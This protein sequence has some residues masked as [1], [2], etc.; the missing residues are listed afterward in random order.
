[1]QED[2]RRRR[3]PAWRADWAGPAPRRGGRDRD[4]RRGAALPARAWCS[5]EQRRGGEERQEVVD[6]AVGDQRRGDAG[7]MGAV[8]QGQQQ[9]GLEH[10]E[11]GRDVADHA[12][13]AGAV[14]R[15]AKAE[16]AQPRSAAAGPTASARPSD[17]STAASSELGR[18]HRRARPG[19]ATSRA[20][21]RAGEKPGRPGRRGPAA[22]AEADAEAARGGCRRGRAGPPISVG[23]TRH[24]MASMAA[25][26]THKVRLLKAT[27]PAISRRTQA[28]AGIEAVADGTAGQ[29][30]QAHGMA[31]GVAD[32]AGEGALPQRQ[33]VPDMMQRQ[34]IVERQHGIAQRGGKDGEEQLRAGQRAHRVGDLGEACRPR[35]RG[36]SPRPRPGT[37]PA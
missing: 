6:Q 8:G 33:L 37:G 1:M 19:E 22:A 18:G 28:P 20:R 5:G 10:A 11:P 25:T 3:R 7:R 16:E 15:P 21:P 32:E 31:E 26:P 17:Q 12:G 29:E 13:D 34:R 30:R 9:H 2:G 27:T 24:P 14:N 36:G 23:A 4:G 35:A